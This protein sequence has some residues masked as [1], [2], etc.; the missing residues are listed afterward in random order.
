MDSLITEMSDLLPLAAIE[1]DAPNVGTFA[2][3]SNIGNGSAIRAPVQE[4]WEGDPGS[5]QNLRLAAIGRKDSELVRYTL[6][7]R[8]RDPLS[9]G[10]NSG[11]RAQDARRKPDRRSTRSRTAPD[12]DAILGETGIDQPLPIGGRPGT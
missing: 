10:R 11:I 9:V 4:Y 5:I 3:A 7:D 8:H 1:R 6:Q 12:G 2:P